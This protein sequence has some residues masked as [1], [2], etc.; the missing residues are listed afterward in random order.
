M[1]VGLL[2]RRV[3]CKEMDWCPKVGRVAQLCRDLQ[4]RSKLKSL[5]SDK[6]LTHILITRRVWLTSHIYR[7]SSAPNQILHIPCNIVRQ[8]IGKSLTIMVYMRNGVQI[9]AD[10]R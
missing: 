2:I 6:L 3:K 5:N 10:L 8:I 1:L 7:D 4:D 9:H